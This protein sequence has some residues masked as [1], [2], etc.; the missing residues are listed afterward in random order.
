M[1]IIEDPYYMV[2]LQRTFSRLM[3]INQYLM[4]A[5]AISGVLYAV[6]V[7]SWIGFSIVLSVSISVKLLAYFRILTAKHQL[8]KHRTSI[9]LGE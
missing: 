4:I 6:G 8:K 7:I 1:K 5:L 9:G 3:P 2:H